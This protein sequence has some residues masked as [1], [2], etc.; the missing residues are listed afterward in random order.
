[1]KKLL[2]SLLSLTLLVGCGEPGGYGL[3][4]KLN[5]K[6]MH[7]YLSNNAGKMEHGDL[8]KQ[9]LIDYYADM[10]ELLE[11]MKQDEEVDAEGLE[12]FGKYSIFTNAL[13]EQLKLDGSKGAYVSN[14]A[15][16]TVTGI[17]V[18]KL[19]G[20]LNVD[21]AVIDFNN[22]S[23]YKAE[24]IY[25][26]KNVVVTADYDFINDGEAFLQYVDE[27]ITKNVK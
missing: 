12:F 23:E 17:M 3:A 8:D 19:E 25:V 9:S 11:E 1:M 7:E 14:L 10:S 24:F 26:Y 15:G 22:Q 20:D 18:Y 6:Q 13:L 27:I 5:T 4:N 2:V 21:Q 16:A